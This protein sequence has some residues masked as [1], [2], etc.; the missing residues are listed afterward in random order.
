MTGFA[1]LS[2]R[3]IATHSRIDEQLALVATLTPGTVEHRFSVNVLLLLQDA[4]HVLQQV[5]ALMAAARQQN[6]SA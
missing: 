2:T 5:E 6:A 3:Q 4:L 1:R